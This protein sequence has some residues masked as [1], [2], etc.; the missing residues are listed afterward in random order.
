MHVISTAEPHWSRSRPPAAH[1]ARPSPTYL[2]RYLRPAPVLLGP[3][4]AHGPVSTSTHFNFCCCSRK[5]LRKRCCASVRPTTPK[6]KHRSI[7]TTTR[8]NIQQ[9]LTRSLFSLICDMANTTGMRNSRLGGCS[10]PPLTSLSD[11]VSNPNVARRARCCQML[12]ASN[13]SE[14]SGRSNQIL[15]DHG[16]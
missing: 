13:C 4:E 7:A 5:I 12:S 3:L 6:A 2:G 1:A 8:I 9:R 11:P 14:S 15:Y 16:L 10:C